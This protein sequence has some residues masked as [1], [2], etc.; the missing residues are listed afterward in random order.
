[1]GFI[2]YRIVQ[3]KYINITKIIYQLVLYFLYIHAWNGSR[4]ICSFPPAANLHLHKTITHNLY[5]NKKHPKYM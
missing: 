1:M 3:L 4:V 5:D 2:H